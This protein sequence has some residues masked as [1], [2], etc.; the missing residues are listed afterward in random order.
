MSISA[1]SLFYWACDK[2]L[3]KD[4]A[5]YRHLVELWQQVKEEKIESIKFIPAINSDTRAV[6]NEIFLEE[7]LTHCGSYIVDV[8][9]LKCLSSGIQVPKAS[10]PECI[11]VIDKLIKSKSPDWV[12]QRGQVWLEKML[13]VTN[14]GQY[15]AQI[16]MDSSE[17]SGPM[18]YGEEWKSNELGKFL[19]KHCFPDLEYEYTIPPK[20]QVVAILLYAAESSLPLAIFG[21]K[22]LAEEILFDTDFSDDPNGFGGI[23][24]LYKL[25]RLYRFGVEVEIGKEGTIT[26]NKLES[27]RLFEDY[28]W[29]EKIMDAYEIAVENAKGREKYYPGLK[30]F[31]ARIVF[32]TL[33]K[34]YWKEIVITENTVSDDYMRSPQLKGYFDELGLTEELLAAKSQ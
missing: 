29:L 16:G 34:D 23:K 24:K 3:T 33:Y 21:D 4:P 28:E 26:N 27:Q 11:E 1:V 8:N 20:E 14:R 31:D 18:I 30:S 9:T 10:L 15:M 7:M 25:I 5:Q 17:I 12:R 22:K 19:A 2:I 6:N 13:I 32:M